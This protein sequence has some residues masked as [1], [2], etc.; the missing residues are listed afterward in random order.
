MTYK[1]EEALYDYIDN[2]SDAFD[3]E[4]IMTFL[5]LI[6]ARGLN[7]MADEISEFIENRRLAFRIE[8]RQWLSR[9]GYFENVP[10]VISPTKLEL[11][12]GILI[13]GHRC[14]PFANP[15][16]LPQEYIFR[17]KGSLIPYTTTE[18]DPK[19]FYPYYCIFGEEYAPQYVASDNPENEA[20]FNDDPYEDP[21]EVSICTLDMR[22]IYRETSFVP[23]DHFVARLADWNKGIFT[24]ERVGAND[25]T[26]QDLHS[27]YEA[28]ET[29]FNKSF[30][31]L[32]PGISTEEQIAYAYWYGGKRMREIP[33]YSLEE[34]LY[35]KTETAE[36]TPFG[37]ETRLWYAGKEIPDLK[38]IEG[39][40]P[41]SDKTPA[42]IYFN[43]KRVPVS[44]YVIRAYVQDYFFRGDNNLAA[45]IDRVIPPAI[46]I[47]KNE[48]K[49][50]EE[51]LS[52]EIME[53]KDDYSPFTD[54]L[55]GPI[56]QRVGE[57]HTAVITLSADLE[58]EKID[59]S[60]LPKHAFIILSQ[61]Q[62]HAAGVM[63]ELDNDESHETI[64]LEAM[65]NSIDSMIETYEDIKALIDEAVDSFKRNRFSLVRN[66]D[67]EEECEIQLGIGGTDVWRR[68]I[69]PEDTSLN[70]L[71]K[72]IQNVFEWNNS[73][74]NNFDCNNTEDFRFSGNTVLDNSSLIGELGNRGL[75]EF[76]YEYGTNWTV[77]I[78]I[79][80]RH[81]SSAVKFIRCVA[82]AGAAPPAEVR[83]PLRYKRM[84]SAL[85]AINREDRAA[86][87]EELGKDFKPDFFNIDTCNNNL[88]SIELRNMFLQRRPQND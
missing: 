69:M 61:I 83:G 22:N 9:K 87:V 31:N 18:G 78:I 4:M 13:P 12:N 6:D 59:S 35:E 74:C 33:A 45:L 30:S 27:W 20:A 52:G 36:I 32:G 48:F 44:E 65:D 39:L 10:F 88:N 64:E 5:H 14:V 51:Y 60:W 3:L 55:T 15:N 56:R 54:K 73:D 67:N 19:E 50:L 28:A 43:S 76:I 34:F 68:I 29:G 53:L 23:G 71:H 40:Q 7:Q 80:T 77:K 46:F 42:E 57:L 72:I 79:L 86:A 26:R 21:P 75:V 2:C 1:Q 84:T 81:A 62:N 8:D 63:E 70:D 16:M 11:L 47:E 66:R 82:G 85:N 49:F 24:L 37:I 38:G 41:G 25:W 17:W 58:K